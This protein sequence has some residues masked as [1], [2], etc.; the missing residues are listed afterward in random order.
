MI[1]IDAAADFSEKDSEGSDNAS[2]CIASKIQELLQGQIKGERP[3][4]KA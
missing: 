1:R 2:T 4:L 3:T